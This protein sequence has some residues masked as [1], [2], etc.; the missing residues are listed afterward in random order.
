MAAGRLTGQRNTVHA[1]LFIVR[2]VGR[3][4]IGSK[5]AGLLAALSHHPNHAFRQCHPY[6]LAS[7]PNVIVIR[8]SHAA[9]PN[10]MVVVVELM[11]ISDA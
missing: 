4:A 6:I 7:T 3:C 2:S 11:V 1:I 10:L 9:Q 8:R 5:E